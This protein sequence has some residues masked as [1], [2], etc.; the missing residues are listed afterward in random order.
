MKKNLLTLLAVFTFVVGL[1]SC[2]GHR[3]VETY[4]END[5]VYT[6][7][8]W[9]MV[10]WDGYEANYYTLDKSIIYH[11]GTENPYR[12]NSG[13]VDGP[14]DVDYNEVIFPIW[15]YWGDNGIYATLIDNT[16]YTTTADEDILFCLSN[17]KW[18]T[19]S[20]EASED[21]PVLITP[22]G[23]VLDVVCIG[24]VAED[25]TYIMNK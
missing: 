11:N 16:M 10:S 7:S 20:A 3:T 14:I 12:V 23:K 25:G 5:T 6:I 4:F 24:H 9:G 17:W 8:D 2:G 22:D 19:R 15:M 13:E 18:Y 1:T 21:K